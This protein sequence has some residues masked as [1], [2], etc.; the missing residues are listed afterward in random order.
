MAPIEEEGPP[1]P[2]P[3][4]PADLGRRQLLIA[5]ILHS[6]WRIHPVGREPLYFG[7]RG[8][9][10]FDAPDASFGVLYLAENPAV[11]FVETFGHETGAADFVTR[12]ALAQRALSE[13]ESLR[14]LRLADL[15]TGKGL[16]PLGADSRLGTGGIDVAQ[17]WAG[18][19][20]G[21]P[22]AP[23]GLLYRARHEPELF[24]VALFDRAADAVR[25]ASTT[26]LADRRFALGLS[27][28]LADYR[29]GLL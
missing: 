7:R 13:V 26:C 10:R 2:H 12:D 23:D 5:E 25:V 16:V 14:I 22:E 24:A 28:I 4:P 18:A 15:T 3:E 17:R 11:A 21:H 9:N 8:R 29:F 1:G 27:R 6:W 19:L 20:H